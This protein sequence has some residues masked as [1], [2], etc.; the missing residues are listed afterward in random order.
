MGIIIEPLNLK[1]TKQLLHGKTFVFTG[2]LKIFNRK[3]AQNIVESLGGGYSSSVGK[4]TDFVVAGES[5]GSK[6][7]KAQKIG[8]PVITEDEFQKLISDK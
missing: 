5:S 3:K 6:L 4:K 2:S 1:S 8:V 7:I